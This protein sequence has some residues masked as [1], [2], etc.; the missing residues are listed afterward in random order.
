MKVINCRQEL[1]LSLDKPIVLQTLLGHL[2][3]DKLTKVL[4]LVLR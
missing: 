1:E 2:L 4:L 3:V